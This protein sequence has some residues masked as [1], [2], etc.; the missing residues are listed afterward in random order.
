MTEKSIKTM[1]RRGV[2]PTSV[3]IL[4][5]NAMAGFGRAFSLGDLETQLDTIDKSTISRTIR[6]FLGKQLIHKFDDGSGSVK[7]SVCQDGCDCGIDDLHVHF[8]CN[9]CK[10]AFCLDNVYVPKFDLPDGMELES[11]NFV[12]KG[13]CGKCGKHAT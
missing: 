4:V 9:Y 11:I 7:Y 6:L 13:Y 10:Q 2:K 12:I 1:D 5:Y 3:R 8:Y